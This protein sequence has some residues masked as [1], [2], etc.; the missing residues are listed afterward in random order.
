VNKINLK[1]KTVE[2][3]VPSPATSVGPSNE[4]VLGTLGKFSLTGAP[5]EV[6]EFVTYL[7]RLETNKKITFAP[8]GVLVKGQEAVPAF[9][10]RATPDVPVRVELQKLTGPEAVA[11]VSKIKTEIEK[12]LGK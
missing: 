9:D 7:Q 4:V 10:V 6:S 5:N 1:P 12:N 11:Y 2:T 3:P 8:Q